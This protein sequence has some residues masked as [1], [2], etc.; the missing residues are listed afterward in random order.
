MSIKERI[1]LIMKMHNLTASALADQLGVQRSNISHI[2]SGRN[3]PS[4]DLLEKLILKFPRVN[5]HWLITGE[6]KAT[7]NESVEVDTFTQSINDHSNA[8]LVS[9]IKFYSDGSCEEFNLRKE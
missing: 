9:V 1:Q 6:A 5:A 4:L 2:I 7:V 3:K 8:K